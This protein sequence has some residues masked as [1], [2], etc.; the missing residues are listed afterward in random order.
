MIKFESR[1]IKK[2]VKRI[3]MTVSAFIVIFFL[4]FISIFIWMR[5]E[6]HYGIGNKADFCHRIVYRVKDLYSKIKH[7]GDSNDVKSVDYTYTGDVTNENRYL[8]IGFDDFRESDFSMVIPLFNEYDAKA[9]FNSIAYPYN[10]NE[11][12]IDDVELVTNSGDEIGNHTWLHR[13]YIYNDALFNGQDPDSLDGEQLPFP[14]NEQMRND[15]GDGCNEFGF[16]L[17]E[18]VIERLIS[19][20]SYTKGDFDGYD[21]S[22]TWKNL[23]DEQ[24]QNIRNEYSLFSNKDGLL[25][26]LDSLSN[27]YLG[28][29]GSSRGSYDNDSGIYTG[30]LFT[31]CHTSANHEV[32]EKL[33][34]LADYYYDD[35]CK[36]DITFFTWSFPGSSCSPFHYVINDKVYYDKDGT[37]LYNYLA[38]FEKVTDEKTI[39]RSFT[40]CLRNNG[41]KIT[42]DTIYP[43][44]NDGMEKCMMSIQ[45]IMNASYS[46]KDALAYSTNRSISY[47]AIATEFPEDFFDNESDK[48]YCTQMY[49]AGGSYYTFIESIRNNTSNGIVQGEVI[50]SVDTYSERKFLR[51]MLD[52]CKVTGVEVVSKATAYDICF[53]NKI[54]DGNLI[55]NPRLRNTAEEFM[56]NASNL[57][58]NPDGYIGDCRVVNKLNNPTLIVEGETKYLHCGIPIGGLLYSAKAKGKGNISIYEVDNKDSIE[59]DTEKL[60]LIK[61][62]S[63]NNVNFEEIKIPFEIKNHNETEFEQLCEGYG[64][65][66][67]GI[68]IVYSSGL[69]VK[70]INLN[71]E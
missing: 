24:C 21:S 52:Y 70:D 53:N 28:T 23:T 16:D 48:D 41:Y 67:M 64:D 20:D 68:L 36:T 30:G 60:K 57:P 43:S 18:P 40:D 55:Y 14:S 65:K 38:R 32:W 35:I 29:K 6:D 71:K 13:C 2:Y 7:I 59:L 34:I 69:E 45:L 11:D 39:S 3:I 63:I 31:G 9:T 47:D 22:I 33:L 19:T 46:R 4:F 56:P 37:I 8:S 54:T 1:T 15:R 49:E 10:M 66:I 62:I 61:T 50:D 27:N 58:T 5:I 25:D 17:N 42:H 12:F 51:G 26:F 44:R